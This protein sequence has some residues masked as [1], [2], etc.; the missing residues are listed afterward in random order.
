[1]NRRPPRP[2][3]TDT[4]FPYTTLFRSC[5]VLRAAPGK[6]WCTGVDVKESQKPGQ[7]VVELDNIWHCEDPGNTLGPKS[8]NCWKPVI[9]AVHGMAA[10]GAFYWLNE[11]DIIICSEDATFFDPHVTY[12][13]TSALEPIGMT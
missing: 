12:G 8:M 6:A 7:A 3:R 2:T 9:A 13:M 1:M 4:L 10:G 11:S 5:C